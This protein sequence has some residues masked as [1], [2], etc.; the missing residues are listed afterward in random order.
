LVNHGPFSGDN[1]GK[2]LVVTYG[3]WEGEKG[4]PAIHTKEIRPAKKKGG[5]EL[6]DGTK[7]KWKTGEEAKSPA[8]R[9]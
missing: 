7:V 4:V 5:E 1:S 2:I 3:G 8:D 9:V 6:W